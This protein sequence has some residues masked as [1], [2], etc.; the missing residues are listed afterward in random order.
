MSALADGLPP[1][2][3]D[4]VENATCPDVGKRLTSVDEF[5][6]FL[7]DVE[8]TL[9]DK[10][11]EAPAVSPLEAVPNDRLP[12]GFTMVRRLGEGSTAVGLLAVREG[13]E[14]VLKVARDAS[15]NQRLVEEAEVLAK[16]DH[17]R[18]VALHDR[19]EMAGLEVLVLTR[20]S[21]RTLARRLREEGPLHLEFLQRWGSDLLEAVH[22]LE[23]VGLAHRD[24][25]PG[26]LGLVKLPPDDAIHLV[27]FDFSL[28]RVPP[29]QVQAGTA[30]Y[31]DPFLRCRPHPRWDVQ[32]ERYAAAVTLYEMAAGVLPRWGD[33]RSDP[34]LV[35]CDLDLE[36]ER[37]DASVRSDL[38]RFFR[39]ALHRKPEQRFD[40][41]EE[42][43][44][45]WEAV[46]AGAYRVEPDPEAASRDR[47]SLV[48]A[49]TL[50]T[51]VTALG[52]SPLAVGSLDRL[53]V[54]KVRDLLTIPGSVVAFLRGVGSRTR[55][56]I[57][58]VMEKLQARFPDVDVDTDQPHGQDVHAVDLVVGELV[59]AGE[60]VRIP[61]AFTHAFLASD[62]EHAGPAWPELSE[63]GARFRKD[64]LTLERDLGA[65]RR[66]WR[67]HVALREVRSD[68]EGLLRSHGGVMTDQ[69]LAEA[70]LSSR[71][72]LS[73]D[74]SRRLRHAAAV[75]RA[76]LE[77]E[78]YEKESR[79][80]W[81]RRGDAVL[82]SVDEERVALSSR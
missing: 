19:V 24:I 60:E 52:L 53:H 66:A 82:V 78:E 22:H 63:L 62:G 31:L 18:I 81:R 59:R 48:E 46:F 21:D 61:D 76:A 75:L 34:A 29:E 17:P 25:K 73:N 65:L 44:A 10:P 69:E 8:E 6:E 37:F 64:P 55:R 54:L 74:P 79:F 20:A 80:L 72:A 38:D 39:R 45:A 51:P 43:R 23:S 33:G 11:D 47:S 68:V 4:V 71:G 26:N 28:S 57:L 16:L 7:A 1:L 14:F 5:L 13:Q 50:E 58:E 3:D 41:A 2:L 15:Q 67:T 77:V 32:A 9:R 27:L 56:E 70:I 42:M 40:N 30:G 35:E 36:V 49:A 12:G